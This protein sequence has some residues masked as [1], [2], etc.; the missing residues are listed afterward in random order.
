MTRGFKKIFF[1]VT[2]TRVSDAPSLDSLDPFVISEH[3]LVVNSDTERMPD[4]LTRSEAAIAWNTKGG[5]T[6]MPGP[7]IN[8]EAL[9]TNTHTSWILIDMTPGIPYLDPEQPLPPPKVRHVPDGV[10]P[11][12]GNVEEGWFMLAI[13]DRFKTLFHGPSMAARIF[14][15]NSST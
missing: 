15:D 1:G 12:A 4:P 2:S 7:S 13:K 6:S 5:S 9:A 3:G 14:F 8:P 11:V 10:I